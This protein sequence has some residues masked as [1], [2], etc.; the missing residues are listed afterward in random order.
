[1]NYPEVNDNHKKRQ[2]GNDKQDESKVSEETDGPLGTL[3]EI[4]MKEL[5]K[6]MGRVREGA[7]EGASWNLMTVI[8]RTGAQDRNSGSG[9][10]SPANR[11]QSGRK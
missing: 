1:M 5:L 2:I 4:L 10:W 3:E 8:I 7:K 11:S 9:W 6:G